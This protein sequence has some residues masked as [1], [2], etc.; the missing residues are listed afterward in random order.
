MP[1]YEYQA[2][3]IDIMEDE[4]RNMFVC[5]VVKNTYHNVYFLVTNTQCYLGGPR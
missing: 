1:C 4:A 2:I 5:V 3:D